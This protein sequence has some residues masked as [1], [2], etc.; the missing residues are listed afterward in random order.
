MHTKVPL[1]KIINC[2]TRENSV[3]N[4]LKENNNHPGNTESDVQVQPTPTIV[5]DRTT[6]QHVRSLRETSLDLT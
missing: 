2:S 5:T 3:T 4:A 1:L 6:R